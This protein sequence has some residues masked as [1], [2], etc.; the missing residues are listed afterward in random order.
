[1]DRAQR[2]KLRVL[3]AA[4]GLA[5]TGA[6]WAE[7]RACA[8]ADFEQVVEEAAG[9]LRDL[10]TKNRPEFQDKLRQLRVKRGWTQDQFLQEAKP[11]VQDGKIADFDQRSDELLS[12][13]SNM[14]QEGVA[15]KKPDCALL[16]E[17][18]ARMK[19]LVDTQTQKWTYMF[20]KIDAELWK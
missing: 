18:R 5:L 14:G 13:I 11:Y 2:G 19:V 1:M 10:N 15:A 20:D 3:L 6:A 12:T 7:D 8:K 4:A 9:S 16:L 17:L